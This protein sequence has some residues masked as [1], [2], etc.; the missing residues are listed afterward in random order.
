MRLHGPSTFAKSAVAAKDFSSFPRIW[1]C[2]SSSATLTNTAA[3]STLER[4]ARMPR[5]SWH[6]IRFWVRFMWDPA[7]INAEPRGFISSWAA[8]FDALRATFQRGRCDPGFEASEK[9]PLKVA[10]FGEAFDF[11]EY[12]CGLV[13]DSRVLVLA[14]HVLEDAVAFGGGKK[15]MGFLP[16]GAEQFRKRIAGFQ[17]HANPV[18]FRQHRQ[19]AHQILSIGNSHHSEDSRIAGGLP[20]D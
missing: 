6:L 9:S 7:T 19:G 4:H 2:R 1:A 5:C 8:L 16:V 11:F 17:A 12:Q 10:A 13:A 3:T 14:R 15:P 18:R 20:A